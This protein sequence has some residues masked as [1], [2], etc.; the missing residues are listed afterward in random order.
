MSAHVTY[1]P[2]SGEVQMDA[3]GARSAQIVAASLLWRQRNDHMQARAALHTVPLPGGV[4][5]GLFAIVWLL[6]GRYAVQ[7]D[8]TPEAVLAGLIIH[9]AGTEGEAA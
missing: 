2:I 9:L 5:D 6:L 4:I 8:R 1:D 3:V 7:T